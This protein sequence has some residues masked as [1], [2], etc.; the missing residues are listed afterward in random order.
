MSD[1]CHRISV[2]L[3]SR[4]PIRIPSP[5]VPANGSVSKPNPPCNGYIVVEKNY[6][7]LDAYWTC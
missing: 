2:L 3:G 4:F 1:K 5:S 6:I 7:L